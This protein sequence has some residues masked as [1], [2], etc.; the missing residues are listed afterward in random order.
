VSPNANT[1]EVRASC[2]R[3]SGWNFASKILDITILRVFFLSR[4]SVFSENQLLVSFLEAVSYLARV[5][6]V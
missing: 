5:S 2:H 6:G 4:W 1:A 3:Q